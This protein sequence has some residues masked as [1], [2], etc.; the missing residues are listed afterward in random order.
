MSRERWDSSV[1]PELRRVAVQLEVR[2]PGVKV[3]S[4]SRHQQNDGSIQQCIQFAATLDVL[5]KVGLLTDAMTAAE[6]SRLIHLRCV[7]PIGDGF[8]LYRAQEE[9]STDDASGW[10]LYLYTGA[11]PRERDRFAVRDAARELRRFMLPKRGRRG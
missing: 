5:R 10:H 2:Y 3:A 11:A 1:A 4:A 8:G 9:S 7:T 6:S